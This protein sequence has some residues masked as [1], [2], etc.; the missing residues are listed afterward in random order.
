MDAIPNH[1]RQRFYA[2]VLIGFYC[3]QRR[4]MQNVF[5]TVNQNFNLAFSQNRHMVVF[6]R[7]LH[8]HLPG[9]NARFFGV[10][11]RTKIMTNHTTTHRDPLAT[12][13]VVPLAIVIGP[14][15]MP[16]VPAAIV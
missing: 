3:Q 9:R 12:V 15:D 14:A 1:I 7:V 4:R 10:Y 5:F 11:A 16:D 2:V 13:T 8:Q 6:M